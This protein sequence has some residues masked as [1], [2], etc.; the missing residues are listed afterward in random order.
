MLGIGECV[1]ELDV[2][3]SI[4]DSME[5]HIHAGDVVCG[6][7][8]FLPAVFDLV[9]W[10]GWSELLAELEEQGTRAACWIVDLADF[11]WVLLDHELC[12]ELRDLLRGVEFAAA[13]SSVAC[14]LVHEE[15]VDVTEDVIVGVGVVNV[16][17]VEDLKDVGDDFVACC[18]GRSELGRGEV[19]VVEKVF[20]V[21]LGA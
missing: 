7:V 11:P 1:S 14:E 21:L 10:V 17:I 9:G 16:E 20:E 2:E 5:D 19:D 4:F 6:N 18:Y 8:D 13:L 15:F 3:V 12:E